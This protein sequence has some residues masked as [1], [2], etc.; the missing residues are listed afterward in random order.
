MSI[1]QFIARWTSPDY[2]PAPV[3]EHAL[4]EA[5]L[6]L[7]AQFPPDYRSAVLRCGLPSPTSALLDSIVERELNVSDVGDFFD[8]ASIVETTL[9]WRAMGLPA[10]LVAFA[11]DCMGNLFCFSAQS[12]G[13]TSRV[14]FFD[15]DEGSVDDVASSFTA[16]I[17]ELASLPAA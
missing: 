6:S 4:A 8:P 13:G 1:E 9:G 2:P 3:E 15:H 12:W 17:D 7:C 14:F 10:D 11:N 16:W 5:E